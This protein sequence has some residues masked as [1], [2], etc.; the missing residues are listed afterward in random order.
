MESTINRE[1]RHSSREQEKTYRRDPYQKER[2][3]SPERS[4]AKLP[5]HRTLSPK[6][7]KKVVELR[8]ESENPERMTRL[9][10]LTE[11]G[12]SIEAA[13][14]MHNNEIE[15]EKVNNLLRGKKKYEATCMAYKRQVGDAKGNS[16]AKD[17]VEDQSFRW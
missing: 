10:D 11:L 7:L 4:A 9:Y 17:E 14:E 12:L 2:N 8:E 16:Q 1:E 15:I 3:R 13:R 5:A 6:T